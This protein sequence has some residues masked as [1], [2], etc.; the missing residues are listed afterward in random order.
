MHESAFDVHGFPLLAEYAVMLSDKH[1][2]MSFIHPG[3]FMR[4]N[5]HVK[6]VKTTGESATPDF[7]NLYLRKE[8]LAWEWFAMTHLD[9]TA[10]KLGRDKIQYTTT[11]RPAKEGSLVENLARFKAMMASADEAE[12]ANMSN[13]TSVG[14][15][16]LV[17]C[18]G[19]GRPSYTPLSA[20]FD[21][22]CAVLR[23]TWQSAPGRA[24][25][26]L[27]VVK[28]KTGTPRNQD[29]LVTNV[30]SGISTNQ[31]PALG[32]DDDTGAVF[33]TVIQ[34]HDGKFRTSVKAALL[35]SSE[36]CETVTKFLDRMNAGSMEQ[37][38]MAKRTAG[39]R[40]VGVMVFETN[41]NAEEFLATADERKLGIALGTVFLQTILMNNATPAC[42]LDDDALNDT[43]D[44]TYGKYSDTVY[45]L[46]HDYVH[47]L[48]ENSEWPTIPSGVYDPQGD[49]FSKS[50]GVTTL[51][52]ADGRMVIVFC[53]KGDLLTFARLMYRYGC[54][55]PIDT[56]YVKEMLYSSG[57]GSTVEVKDGEWGSV[58]LADK[59]IGGYI[60]R[61]CSD[62]DGNAP[63]TTASNGDCG[64]LFRAPMSYVSEG[65][66]PSR[67]WYTTGTRS[68][69]SVNSVIHYED[70]GSDCD[71]GPCDTAF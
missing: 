23:K 21:G 49:W 65:R 67:E 7:G 51:K 69:I 36:C 71:P 68:T 55:F 37:V 54:G 45:R 28:K 47:V 17:T 27:P 18:D 41:I 43:N 5:E 56:A 15:S 30:Y 64:P 61:S 59:I 16:F 60:G 12:M 22:V 6:L 42:S 62:T 38:H 52:D 24:A 50:M 13:C 3:G 70:D 20:M 35:C 39:T 32:S 29:V 4:S 1:I 44:V 2:D 25:H 53:V 63:L 8:E 34:S 10:G 11:S 48:F 19:Y 33:P 14:S 26:P 31:S 58:K 66:S 40:R 9:H 46:V 57:D